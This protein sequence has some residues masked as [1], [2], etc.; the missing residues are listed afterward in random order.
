MYS[1]STQMGRVLNTE[2][3]CTSFISYF[4]CIYLHFC[5]IR[6][7][8]HFSVIILRYMYI[9]YNLYKTELL[10]HFE[11]RG[12]VLNIKVESPLC[13]TTANPPQ[14]YHSPRVKSVTFNETEL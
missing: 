1:G 8:V 13:T 14:L 3:L 7:I 9:K 6:I 12:I 2:I 5:F 11:V 10:I 4:S